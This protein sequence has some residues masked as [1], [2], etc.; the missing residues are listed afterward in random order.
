MMSL[1]EVYNDEMVHDPVEAYF[2]EHDRDVQYASKDYLYEDADEDYGSKPRWNRY[3][4][5][6]DDGNHSY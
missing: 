1:E 2:E 5:S 4:E 3:R 6:Y